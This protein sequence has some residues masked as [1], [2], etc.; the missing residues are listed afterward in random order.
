[1]TKSRWP[2]SQEKGAHPPSTEVIEQ[3]VAAGEVGP[4]ALHD[5]RFSFWEG[6]SRQARK[7]LEDQQDAAMWKALDGIAADRPKEG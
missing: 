2:T 7:D 6:I 5:M 1:M 3:D 4:E